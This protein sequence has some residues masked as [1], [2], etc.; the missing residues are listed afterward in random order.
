M[1]AKLF[2]WV[3]HCTKVTQIEDKNVFFTSCQYIDHF[4][5]KIDTDMPKRDLQLTA[6]AC[7]FIA[8]K[9]L[10]TICLKLSFCRDVLGHKKFSSQ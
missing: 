6:I 5:A 2:D 10:D 4:Y 8:S 9:L 7:I 3:L 1:R